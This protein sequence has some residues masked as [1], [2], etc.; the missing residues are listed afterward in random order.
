MIISY[1]VR[2][3][4]RARAKW[5]IIDICKSEA[6]ALELQQAVEYRGG[7]PAKVWING[8]F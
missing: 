4:S 2:M 7:I 3:W 6:D 8:G 1:V 5:V